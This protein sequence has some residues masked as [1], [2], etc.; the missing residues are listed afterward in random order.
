MQHSF[1]WKITSPIRFLRR[2]KDKLFKD[3]PKVI[4]HQK[5]SIATAYSRKNR[6]QKRENISSPFEIKDLYSKK[7]G[8]KE[9]NPLTKTVSKLFG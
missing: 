7:S 8:S 5:N 1:S 9:L 2:Y 4:N 3:F 6:K